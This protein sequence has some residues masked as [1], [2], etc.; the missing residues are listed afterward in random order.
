MT[1][2]NPNAPKTNYLEIN[3][4]RFKSQVTPSLMPKP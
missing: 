2:D 3:M 1:F 4:I